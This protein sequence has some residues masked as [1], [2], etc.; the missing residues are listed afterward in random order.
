M[1]ARFFETQC[2]ITAESTSTYQLW[3]RKKLC[4]E[5]DGVTNG[6]AED[7][8][9]NISRQ[10]TWQGVGEGYFKHVSFHIS[11]RGGGVTQSALYWLQHCEVNINIV[12]N[13]L[14]CSCSS[15][16]L[17]RTRSLQSFLLLL[18]LLLLTLTALPLTVFCQY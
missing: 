7:N 3:S 16:A 1:L 12:I 15:S 18:P 4:G 17:F 5:N 14:E 9:L 10:A 11:L 6:N 8:I 13:I 2:I